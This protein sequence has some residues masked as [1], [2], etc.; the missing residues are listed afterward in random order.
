MPSFLNSHALHLA[1]FF[2]CYLNASREE[3]ISPQ[4]KELRVV[5]SDELGGHSTLPRETCLLNF[6]LINPNTLSVQCGSAPSC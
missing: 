6:L 5:R 4:S 1:E 2:N 3:F